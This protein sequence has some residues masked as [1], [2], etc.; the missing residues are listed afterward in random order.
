[1]RYPSSSYYTIYRIPLIFL[2]AFLL[3]LSCHGNTPRTSGSAING[4]GQYP[5]V[6]D[7]IAALNAI[8]GFTPQGQ[9]FLEQVDL[10]QMSGQPGWFG[11]FGYK[12]WT[13]VGEANPASIMHELGHAY[14]GAFSVSGHPDLRWNNHRPRSSSSAM[15]RYHR[16]LI[17]FMGQP[18]D[19][20]EPLRERLRNLPNVLRGETSPLIHFGEADLVHTVGGNLQL[21][22]PLLRKYY[23]QY[24]SPGAFDSWYSVLQ[25][26]LG[27]SQED[28]LATRAFFG[29]TH[30]D[31]SLYLE[32][33]PLEKTTLPLEIRAILDQEEKQKLVDFARQFDIIT[34]VEEVDGDVF[35]L[36]LFFFRSYL[37]DKLSLY[38]RHPETLAD[39]EKELPIAADLKRVMEVFLSLDGKSLENRTEILSQH[40]VEPFFFNFWPL[41]DNSLLMELYGLGTVV[42]DTEP[43]ERTTDQA[44][45]RL[46]K[47]VERASSILSQAK[48]DISAGAMELEEFI[49]ETL[50]EDE[51]DIGLIVELL[52]AADYETTDAM[53][54]ELDEDLV[55]KLLEETSGTLRQLLGPE[56]LLPL[57]GITP[58][59]SVD[60]MVRGVRDLLEGT[61]GNFR[62]DQPYFSTVYEIVARRGEVRPHEALDILRR[63]GMFPEE[64]IREYPQETVAILSSDLEEAAILIAG[65][66]GHGRNPQGLIHSIISVNPTLASDLVTRLD[67]LNPLQ[68]QEALIYFA[69]DSYRKARLPSLEVSLQKDGAFLLSLADLRGPQWVIERMARV[70]AI[71]DGY[72]K[73]GAV[74]PNFLQEYR[75]T[76]E[77][78]AGLINGPEARAMLQTLTEKAFSQAGLEY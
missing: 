48:E 1:M 15:S 78:A 14:W 25:W 55:R 5:W 18:P 26:Y 62:I 73:E 56:D 63:S 52:Q 6:Q 39:L 33:E 35:S 66:E 51:G 34:G 69:Y 64:L 67:S 8:Y 70:V 29:L 71:Y 21:L 76:L 44:I 28:S 4:A 2:T 68:V 3:T 59:A 31:L 47:T 30:L 40:L 45:E 7:R 53:G 61:S 50:G 38:K 58:E 75:N 19:P 20:Y 49:W 60:D 43:L 74:P 41:V 77:E 10:R 72:S 16:D 9:R 32:L 12:E 36:D 17:I 46:G 57:L 13:G 65:V 22:P 11:S 54:R 27:L 24:L 42:Q 23:D 37:R